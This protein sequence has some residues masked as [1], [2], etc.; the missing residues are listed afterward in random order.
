VGFFDVARVEQAAVE[1]RNFAELPRH[2][3]GALAALPPEDVEKERLEKL[4]V[5][6]S[7]LA[8]R[9]GLLVFALEVIRIRNQ[10]AAALLGLAFQAQ[11]ALLLQEVE[12]HQPAHQQLGVFKLVVGR[13]P[14]RPDCLLQL[15]LGGDEIA[16]EVLRHAL[17]V[18]GTLPG[19]QDFDPVGLRAGQ[20]QQRQ[21]LQVGMVDALAVHPELVDHLPLRIDPQKA[22]VIRDD[23][24]VGVLG[25]ELPGL[26]NQGVGVRDL[27][28]AVHLGNPYANVFPQRDRASDAADS[29]EMK[30]RRD[31]GAGQRGFVGVFRGVVQ[32][33]EQLEQ[34]SPAALAAAILADELRRREKRLG[35]PRPNRPAAAALGSCWHDGASKSQK[36]RGCPKRGQDP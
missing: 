24:Q 28:E 30:S 23:E 2:R 15:L 32:T 8:L 29:G 12:E 13:K 20:L 34:P 26:V 17:D 19:A 18:E 25:R 36:L 6:G 33:P 35:G 4:V 10:P 14:G 21:R 27:G 9:T 31:Q 16:V 3:G 5:E 22:L 11:P 1:E 7:P